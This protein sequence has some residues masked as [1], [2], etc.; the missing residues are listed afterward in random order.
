[1]TLCFFPSNDV[2]FRIPGVFEKAKVNGK[3]EKFKYQFERKYG[4]RATDSLVKMYVAYI[5][6]NCF[7]IFEVALGIAINASLMSLFNGISNGTTANLFSNLSLSTL[8]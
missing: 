1:M 6:P 4:N 8:W 5:Y 2:Y 3:V 7:L